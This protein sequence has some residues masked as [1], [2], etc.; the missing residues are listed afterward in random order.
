MKIYQQHDW[1][2]TLEEAIAIQE[3]LRNQTIIEDKL[4][5]TIKYVAGVDMGFEADGTISHAAVAVLSFPD[6]Q[7]VETAVA[8]RPTS[9]PYIPG[10]LSFREI[11]A[12]LDALEKVKILP[13]II[14]CDGQGI[15]HPRRLGIASHLGL[16]IDMPTIGVA[17]SLLIGKYDEVPETKG[18]WQPLIHQGETIGA[19][20]RTRTGVKPLYISSGHRISLPT[21][22]DYVLRCTTKYR[23]P[24]TTRIADKLASSR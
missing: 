3:K 19:V 23:L 24:E 18:S 16:L 11:P 14:L 22:I 1:P 10:F 21:A 12:V 17:K 7:I 13:D 20:L 6:L 9:F 8:R 2:Q 4:P 15:A 5:E